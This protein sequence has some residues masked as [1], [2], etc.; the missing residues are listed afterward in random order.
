MDILVRERGGGHAHPTGPGEAGTWGS[1]AVA[2]VLG[3]ILMIAAF[4][5]T[6]HGP[7]RSDATVLLKQAPAPLIPERAL[8]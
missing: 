3:M 7:V 8:P 6:D 4:E 1:V 5:W 2:V